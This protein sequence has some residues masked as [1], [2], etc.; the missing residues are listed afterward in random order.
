M[1]IYVI[2]IYKY[3]DYLLFT[4]DQDTPL[5][6]VSNLS[7]E[8]LNEDDKNNEYNNNDVDNYIGVGKNPTITNER[9]CFTLNNS[10]YYYSYIKINY[11]Y[12]INYVNNV[13]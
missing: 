13:I 5:S 9:V 12:I 10:S 3:Y 2:N 1:L 7:P 11:I 4:K 8:N 6:S